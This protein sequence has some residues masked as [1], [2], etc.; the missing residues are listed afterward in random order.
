MRHCQR[1]L[2]SAKNNKNARRHL[3]LYLESSSLAG[4]KWVGLRDLL[5]DVL[6]HYSVVD[7]LQKHNSVDIKLNG[8]EK[9]LEDSNSIILHDL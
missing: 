4:V 1:N 9:G 5:D 7:P 6:H 8:G 3:Q 2:N